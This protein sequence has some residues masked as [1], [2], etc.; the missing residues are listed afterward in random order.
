MSSAS[1]WV[2]PQV[3]LCH[4]HPSPNLQLCAPQPEQGAHLEARGVGAGVLAEVALV[5]LLPGVDALVA[6]Q[7]ALLGEGLPALLTEVRAGL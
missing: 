1:C 2:S 6:P 5:G 3:S 7:G 4:P